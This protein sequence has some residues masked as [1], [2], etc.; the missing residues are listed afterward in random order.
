MA[1]HQQKKLP[2]LR[3]LTRGPLPFD[4]TS[5]SD[6]QIIGSALVRIADSLDR[7]LELGHRLD[8]RSTTTEARQKATDQALAGV[9]GQITRLRADLRAGVFKHTDGEGADRT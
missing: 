7:L 4:Q 8:K 3:D 1:Q 5:P 9:K 6:V 2:D